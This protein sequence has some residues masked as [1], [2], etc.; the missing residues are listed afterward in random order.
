MLRSYKSAPAEVT[1]VASVETQHPLPRCAHMHCL[2]PINVRQV[3]MNVSGFIFFSVKDFSGTPL[4]HVRFH[5]RHHF[6]RL[7]LCCHL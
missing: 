5:V 7:S 1:T 6:V 2:G 3:V 4:L